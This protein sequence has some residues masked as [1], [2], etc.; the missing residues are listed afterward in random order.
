MLA[1][2]KCIFIMYV[3]NMFNIHNM[4]DNIDITNHPEYVFR[5]SYRRRTAATIDQDVLRASLE[6]PMDVRD[7][8]T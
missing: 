5:M 3:E 1:I 2:F 8:G 7:T 4:L 6:R